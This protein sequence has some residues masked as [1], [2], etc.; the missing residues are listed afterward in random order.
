MSFFSSVLPVL[1]RQGHYSLTAIALLKLIKL[2]WVIKFLWSPL[3]DRHTEGVRDYKRWIIGAEIVY[4][5]LILIVSRLSIHDH[6]GLVVPL[7][8]L[9]FLMSA[10]QDIA[11]DALAA[12]SFGRQDRGL[13]NSMQ[14]MGAFAGSMIGSGLL[15]LLFHHIGWSHLL[16]WVA[17][18]VLVALLPL[19][20]N[21]KMTLEPR[22]SGQRAKPKDMLTFFTQKGMGR[23]ILFLLLCYAGFMGILSNLRPMLIDLGY[24]IKQIGMMVGIFGTTLG[25]G[26]S[27]L[28]GIGIQRLGRM[29]MQHLTGVMTIGTTLFYFVAESTGLLES[30]TLIGYLAIG[31]VWWTYGMASTLIYTIA[32]DIVRE[33]REGTDFTI[34]IVVTHISSMVFVLLCSRIADSTGYRGMFAFESIISIIVTLY[35][36]RY[37]PKHIES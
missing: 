6:F 1:M 20:T 33:G 32:M 29:T 23:H 3:V 22:Q 2:P 11:T 10:T 26:G 18:F 31:L 27:L 35:I 21:R 24:N 4:A 19:M 25:I 14:T 12:R 7:I 34:Q 36:W 17:L 28:T 8:L 9:A 13:L 15:L 37:K 16:P 30:N 5:A